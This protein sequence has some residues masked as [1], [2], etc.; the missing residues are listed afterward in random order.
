MLLQP[1]WGRILD[2]TRN[3]AQLISGA[4]GRCHSTGLPCL[5]ARNARRGLIRAARFMDEQV[6]DQRIYYG[7]YDQIYDYPLPH[8]A[9]AIAFVWFLR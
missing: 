6:I 4:F 3:T 2:A 5:S 8:R 7:R 1:P 9:L